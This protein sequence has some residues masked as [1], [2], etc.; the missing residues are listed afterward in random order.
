MGANKPVKRGEGGPQRSAPS[1]KSGFFLKEIQTESLTKAEDARVLEAA[2]I[3]P[4]RGGSSICVWTRSL[5][6]GCEAV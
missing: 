2:H 6:G 3:L 5:A 1:V 4:D